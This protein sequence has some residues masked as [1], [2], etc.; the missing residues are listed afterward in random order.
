MY[1]SW[2]IQ[3]W[4]TAV[5]WSTQR[6]HW[7]SC[8]CATNVQGVNKSIHTSHVGQPQGLRPW[9]CFIYTSLWLVRGLDW[10][11]EALE[12]ACDAEP[13]ICVAVLVRC[14]F[15]RL[16]GV[17]TPIYNDKLAFVKACFIALG[18]NMMQL[19]HSIVVYR[20]LIVHT[21]VS[22]TVLRLRSNV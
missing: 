9:L 12:D 18:H 15:Y 8:A 10:S 13:S 14:W 3:S 16:Y 1:C 19:V 11:Q 7:R 2:C 5:L 17:T 4:F 21:T 20:H 6:S 22:W